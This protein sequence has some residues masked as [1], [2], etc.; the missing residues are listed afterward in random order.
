MEKPVLCVGLVCLDDVIVVNS[1]PKED[2]DQRSVD[3]Y[4]S[5]GGNASNTCTVLAEIGVKVSS[6]YVL[7]AMP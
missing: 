3:Q 7:I 2:T 5:R 4:K 1:F 6:F